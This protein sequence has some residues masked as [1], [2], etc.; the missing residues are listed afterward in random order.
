MN[1]ND[2]NIVEMNRLALVAQGIDDQ[3]RSGQQP[4]PPEEKKEEPSVPTADLLL[5]II[6]L[7]CDKIVPAWGVTQDEK[8]MLSDVYA[9][10]IDKWFPDGIM[11]VEM[12]AIVVTAMIVLPRMDMQKKKQEDKETV[13]VKA[14]ANEG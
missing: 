1:E 12:T 14:A 8:K 5:P 13:T 11:G 4:P 6:T 2:N 9:A 3:D 10:V 7:C